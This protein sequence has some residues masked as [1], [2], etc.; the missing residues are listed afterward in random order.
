MDLCEV[1]THSLWKVRDIK[2]Q[3]FD[4]FGGVLS[5]DLGHAGLNTFSCL[6]CMMEAKKNNIRLK[7]LKPLVHSSQIQLMSQKLL[8]TRMLNNQMFSKKK[9]GRKQ[10]LKFEEETLIDIM[11]LNQ[12]EFLNE[13]ACFK[14]HCSI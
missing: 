5:I 9:Q 3:F 12:W 11:N 14:F 7:F 4:N 10:I 6:E 1:W 13:N 2:I 8:K